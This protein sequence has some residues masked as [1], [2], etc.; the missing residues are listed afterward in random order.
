MQFLS[1]I[2]DLTVDIGYKGLVNVKKVGDNGTDLASFQ[3][4]VGAS[5]HPAT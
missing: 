3:A 4:L 2:N 1:M 5:S